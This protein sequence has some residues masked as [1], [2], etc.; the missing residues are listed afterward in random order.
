MRRTLATALSLL[1]LA[2]CRERGETRGDVKNP[3]DAAREPAAAAPVAPSFEE[4]H[5]RLLAL[6]EDA[7][8]SEALALLRRMEIDFA[9]HPRASTLPGTG[10][11]IGHERRAALDLPSAVKGLG[12]E[13][14]EVVAAS[15]KELVKAGTAGRILLRKAVLEED[16]RMAIEAVK[17]LVEMDRGAPGPDDATGSAQRLSARDAFRARLRMDPPE[18]LRSVLARA[19]VEVSREALQGA[20]ANAVLAGLYEIVKDDRGFVYREVA[21][22]VCRFFEERL[23]KDK[24]KLARAVGDEGAY[25]RLRLY[26]QTALSSDDGALSTWAADC[27]AAVELMV[28]G[29]RGSYYHGRNFEKLAHE[30]LDGKIDVPER[31]FPYPDGRQD[32][33]TVR[34]TGFVRIE[35]AGKYTFYSASDD[36]QRLWVDGKQLVNDWAMHGVLEKSGEIALEVGHYPFKVEFMQGAGGASITVSWQGPGFDKQVIPPKAFITI[37]WQGME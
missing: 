37:P 36:G 13:S 10:T 34:W 18:A 11:R 6:E 35:K 5:E 9:D 17:L 19:L 30:Q 27:A 32:D 12:S 23:G 24:A 26:V 31:K 20:N 16:G 22:E 29:L 21:G 2:G 15:G 4:Q 25:A 14:A 1:L 28:P 8:F 3:E 7:R 33:I